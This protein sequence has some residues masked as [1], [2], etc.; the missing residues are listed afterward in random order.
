M[1]NQ[2]DYD[3]IMRQYK[4]RQFQAIHSREDRLS[5]VLN[6]LP[7]YKELD[8]CIASCSLALTKRLL[9]GDKS[10][11]DEIS[12]TI[13]RL[14][15]QKAD[16]LK[17]A[18]FPEDYLSVQYQCAKCQDTGYVQKEQCS[19]L[20]KAIA[21]KLSEQSGLN[22][23]LK[24]NNF[25]LLS[26]EYYE[27]EDLAHFKNAVA[28]CH[29]FVDNFAI[30][31][32]NLLFYGNVG[33][34]KSFLSCCIA[35]ELIDKGY[36]VNY[37]SSPELFRTMSDILF[38]KGEYNLLKSLRES[39]FT[40]DLLIVDDLGTELTNTAVASELFSLL[41]ERFLRSK[42]TIIST[43]LGLEQLQERYADRIF[44]RLMER[45]SFQKITGPDIRREKRITNH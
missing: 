42:S 23:I 32:K 39:I 27:G 25:S 7:Q 2:S 31:Y 20:K 14:T 24:N 26:T 11:K 8:D 21:D 33:T 28:S 36:S 13:D 35:K 44:S 43:N 34:G 38:G 37:F 6:T 40:S 15:R 9:S 41:N 29:K 18:G 17:E 1:L 10:A 19:C 3:A 5:H 4:E 30:D 45:F 22:A 16:V 12:S